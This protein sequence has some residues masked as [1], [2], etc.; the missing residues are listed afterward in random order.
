MKYHTSINC[1]CMGY[2]FKNRTKRRDLFVQAI[3]SNLT[4]TASPKITRGDNL[5]VLEMIRIP[6]SAPLT[7]EVKCDLNDPN[8]WQFYLHCVP[9]NCEAEMF[10][11]LL[12]QFWNGWIRSFYVN[13]NEMS[14]VPN[15]SSNLLKHKHWIKYYA[16][17][18][19]I[20]IITPIK[21]V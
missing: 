16:I 17:H 10:I 14:L 13:L 5:Q 9:L 8:C 12:A 21:H 4:L 1:S 11:S 15:T 20:E 7:F 18:T 6:Y 3:E 19:E 2:S